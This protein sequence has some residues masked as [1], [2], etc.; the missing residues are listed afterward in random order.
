[1]ETW[2]KTMSSTT[3]S[4]K[5][6]RDMVADIASQSKNFLKTHK[7]KVALVGAGLAASLFI[8]GSEKGEDKKY[9]TYDE[10]YNNQYYGT[11]FADWQNRNNAHK[12]LY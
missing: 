10:L 6:G 8:D 2:I 5:S 12:V 1:M 4:Q 9:N 11:G 3:E 7:N